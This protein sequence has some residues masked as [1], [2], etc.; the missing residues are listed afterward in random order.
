MEK[1]M[2][3]ANAHRLTEIQLCFGLALAVITIALAIEDARHMILPDRLNAIFA[4]VGVA[5]VLLVGMP[6]PTNA[7]LGAAVG[8]GTALLL[9]KGFEALR[10]RAGL[11][12]GDQKFIAAAGLWIGVSELPWM[13]F[14]TSTSALLFVAAKA[15]LR[16]NMDPRA[17]V[18][19]GPFLAVGTMA[20][21]L[22]SALVN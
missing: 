12:R 16:G 22:W 21:W 11:G 8:A 3:T 6:T 19:F 1:Q 4:I 18:P 14:L 17:R 10:G 5:Q 13:L 15:G 9:A 7:A 2:I 20:T